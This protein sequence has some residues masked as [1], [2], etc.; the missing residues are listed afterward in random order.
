MYEP[1]NIVTKQMLRDM[2]KEVTQQ[3][4]RLGHL[5]TLCF[6]ATKSLIEQ[7][8]NYLA[9]PIAKYVYTTEER[10]QM[11]TKK[12]RES[13]AA[14]S[15]FLEEAYANLEKLLEDLKEEVQIISEQTEQIQAI[16]SSEL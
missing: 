5:Y 16:L 13:F 7:A 8:H 15:I 2:L 12:D 11:F 10:E 14:A 6:D 9:E 4:G 3:E 1:E